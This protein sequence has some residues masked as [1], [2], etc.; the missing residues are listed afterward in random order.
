MKK[1][2]AFIVEDDRDIAAL[3][4]HVLDMAGYQTEVLLDGQDA[5]NLLSSMQPDI[6][7][8]DLQ[9]PSVSGLDILKFIRADERLR[10]TSVIVVTAFAH[11]LDSLPAEPDLVMLKPVDINHLSKLARRLRGTKKM[12]EEHPYDEVTNLYNISFF[13]VRMLYALERIK[14]LELTRFGV[15]FAQLDG[16]AELKEQ[17]GQSV[18]NDFL[19][20]VAAK[21]S[22]TVRPTDTVAWS[23]DGYFL[24]LVDAIVG[25]EAA[26]IIGKRVD[27]WLTS[28]LETFPFATELRVKTG[29]L[30][31]DSEY[32]DTQAIMDD[33][34]FA[35]N[36]PQDGR[37]IEKRLYFRESLQALRSR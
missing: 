30:I 31:C 12:A 28:Y 24:I 19:R 6:V 17:V 13:S 25:D 14:Q 11:Y 16:L 34:D 27:A 23:P 29:V 20:E 10:T 26:L 7:F 36:Q 9:L 32:E 1:P 18:F 22:S 4:R 8:L 15:M 33:L 5:I 21:I 37:G 2:L 35:R 3:F